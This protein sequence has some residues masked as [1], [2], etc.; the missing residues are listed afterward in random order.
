[1]NQTWAVL[2]LTHNRIFRADALFIRTENTVGARLIRAAIIPQ[3]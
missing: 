3:A 1:M 2:V